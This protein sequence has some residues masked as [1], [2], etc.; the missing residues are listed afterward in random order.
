MANHQPKNIVYP[1]NHPSDV[2][3]SK[4]GVKNIPTV[5]NI[6]KKNI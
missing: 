3:T 6:R 4:Y 5:D 2:I 1:M